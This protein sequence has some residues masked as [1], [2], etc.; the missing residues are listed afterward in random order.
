MNAIPC[1]ERNDGDGSAAKTAFASSVV[2]SS[3]VSSSRRERVR[4]VAYARTRASFL[5]S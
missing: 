1:D 4:I 3:R 5:L 2:M